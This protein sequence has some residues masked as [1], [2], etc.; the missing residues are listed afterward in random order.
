MPSL[1]KVYFAA[2]VT[3]AAFWVNAALFTCSIVLTAGRRVC[4]P[5]GHCALLAVRCPH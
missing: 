1:A 5:N 2:I 3:S 4:Y